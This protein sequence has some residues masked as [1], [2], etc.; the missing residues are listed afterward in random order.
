MAIGIVAQGKLVFAKGFGV[1]DVNEPDKV[2]EHT[3]F[4]IGSTTKAFTAAVLAKM[5]DRKKLGWHDKVVDHLPWFAMYDPWVTCQF[6]V[7]DLMA[8]RSGL[9][10]YAGDAQAFMGY[11]RKHIMR[12][13]RYIKPITS[14]RSQFAYVN[15]PFVVAGALGEK[16]TGK[17]WEQNIKEMFFKPLGMASTSA[18]LKGFNQ[19]PNATRLHVEDDDKITTLPRNW[20]QQNWVYEYGPAGG[21]KF[22]RGRHGQVAQVPDGRRH[23]RRQEDPEQRKS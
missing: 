15:G 23:L 1:K 9:M 14:F 19:A 12:S 7:T 16:L 18:C 22:Q 20:P 2:D 8:Q 11:D 21:I 6:M 10:A 13:L 5:V 3:I 17:P 4:Q